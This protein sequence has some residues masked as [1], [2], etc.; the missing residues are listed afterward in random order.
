MEW[1]TSWYK[2]SGCGCQRKQHLITLT[3]G[4]G[5]QI[6][7]TLRTVPPYILVIRLNGM[8][9][10]AYRKLTLFVKRSKFL[11]TMWFTVKWNSLVLTC[12]KSYDIASINHHTSLQVVSG[13]GKC[14]RMSCS[15]ANNNQTIA[16]YW[17]RL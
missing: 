4:L 5:N 11:S 10:H 13:R 16:C 9:H 12:I 3:G 8:T 6:I 17:V 15:F 1:P 7:I 14:D 2:E